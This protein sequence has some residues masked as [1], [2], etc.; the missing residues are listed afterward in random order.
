MRDLGSG[1][2]TIYAFVVIFVIVK[3]GPLMMEYVEIQFTFGVYAIVVLLGSAVLY[4][5]MPETKN[6][7]LQQV[8]DRLSSRR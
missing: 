5:I 3:T 1:V 7:T 4:F 6:V 8:E 2:T